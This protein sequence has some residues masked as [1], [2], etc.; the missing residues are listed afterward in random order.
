MEQI[1]SDP[2]HKAGKEYAEYL[3]LQAIFEHLNGKN[4]KSVDLLIEAVTN[5][6]KCIDS[7]KVII[8]SIYFMTTLII[9]FV[10]E[11]TK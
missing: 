7:L 5:N 3:I 6:A 9:L 2:S 10:T 1:F 11:N 4:Q 8:Q